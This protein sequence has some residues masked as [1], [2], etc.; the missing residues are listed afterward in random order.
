MSEKDRILDENLRRL[1]QASLGEENQ[2]SAQVQQ[3]VYRALKEEAAHLYGQQDFPPLSLALLGVGVLVGSIWLLTA[4]VGFQT[5]PDRQIVTL[6]F[7]LLPGLNL[8]FTP[9]AAYLIIKRKGQNA[10]KTI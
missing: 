5:S 6:L 4:G 10:N 9:I 8:F 2:P 7:T 1:L 3:T